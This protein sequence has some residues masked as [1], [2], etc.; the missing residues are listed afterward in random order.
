LPVVL[1]AEFLVSFMEWVL[2]CTSIFLVAPPCCV[3]TDRV[4][5]AGSVSF[6]FMPVL[7]VRDMDSLRT[8][9]TVVLLLS[10]GRYRFVHQA[11][12]AQFWENSWAM[13]A[14]AMFPFLR[15]LS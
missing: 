4:T 6:V 10:V 9:V 1:L 14:A 2:P 15:A 13:C 5:V 7:L 12:C 11:N 3:A 8:I